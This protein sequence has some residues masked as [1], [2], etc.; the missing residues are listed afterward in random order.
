MGIQDIIL[1]KVL[2]IVDNT[3]GKKFKVVD[4]MTDMFQD[5]VEL[6]VLYDRRMDDLEQRIKK[7]EEK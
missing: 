2:K 7:L 1:K 3:I 6:N 4:K 5:Q